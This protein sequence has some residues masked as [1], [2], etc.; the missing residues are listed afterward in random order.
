MLSWENDD[1]WELGLV[2]KSL[3]SIWLISNASLVVAV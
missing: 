3:L 1:F 2:R